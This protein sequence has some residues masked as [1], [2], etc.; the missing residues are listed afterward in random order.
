EIRQTKVVRDESKDLAVE[1]VLAHRVRDRSREHDDPDTAKPTAN[2]LLVHDRL[3]VDQNS[4]SLAAARADC[5]ETEPAAV[6]AQLVDHRPEYARARRADRMTERN[7]PA[8]DVHALGIRVEH[9]RAVQH[10]G[11]ERLVQLDAFDVADLLPRLR[12][13]RLPGL[14]RRACETREVVRD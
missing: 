1:A 7:R 3:D 8:V 9:L 5:G 13:R 10:D 11:R 14:R 2:A 12:Q 4:V 6:A